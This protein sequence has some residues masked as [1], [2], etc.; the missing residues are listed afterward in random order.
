MTVPPRP[1]ILGIGVGVPQRVVSNHELAQIVETS[2]EWIVT[3]TGIRERRFLGNGE[4]LAGIGAQAARKALENAHLTVGD[5]DFLIA[6]TYTPE[7]QCPSVACELHEALG[8]GMKPAIDI[9]AACSGY[10]YAVHFANNLIRAGAHRNILIVSLEAQS[11][12]L[13]FTDRT[14]CVLFGDGAAATVIG[15]V[16]DGARSQILA[17]TVGADGTGK[18]MITHDFGGPLDTE[19]PHARNGKYP[20]LRMNGREVFKFAVRIVG[21]ALDEVLALSGVSASDVD[22]LI[23][24][25]ANIRIINAAAERLNLP[26]ERVMANIEKY[27]NTASVTIPLALADAIE[28]GRLKPGDHLALVAFGAGYTYGSAIVKW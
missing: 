18:E 22:L 24:H 19:S 2:D 25:Q 8:L 10:L 9:N 7:R 23:P 11:K 26:P 20:F 16:E 6:C 4:T 5:I 12:Y 13:D 27:G 17:T 3:R 14:T 21:P 1:G 28:Q 15:A